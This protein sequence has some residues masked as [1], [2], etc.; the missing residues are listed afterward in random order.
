MKL[1]K[2][3]PLVPAAFILG[4]L[5]LPSGCAN[6]TTPPS[7]GDKDTI[8]PV[9][10]RTSPLP[11]TVNVPTHRTK[12]VFT[13]NEYVK[14]KDANGVFLSPPLRKSPR[15]PSA[16]NPWKSPSKATWTPTPPTRWT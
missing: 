13:F 6:T 14:I 12:L 16:A 5:F 10:L 3:L 8:P 2:L 7:G 1:K 11:G 15:P 9:L 4:S